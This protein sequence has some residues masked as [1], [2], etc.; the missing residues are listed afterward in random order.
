MC[1]PAC[2]EFTRTALDRDEVHEAEVLE[3]GSRDYNGTVRALIEPHGPKS[4]VGLDMLDG[5]GVD[6]VGDAGQLVDRFGAEAFDVVIATELL[7]HARRWR[8]VVNAL[9]EVLRPGGLLV[10]TTRSKGFPF[11]GCPD[12]FWRYEAHDFAVIFDDLLIDRLELDDP[13]TPGVLLR[14]RKPE[15]YHQKD[16]KNY[17]LY[18]IIARRRVGDVDPV[19][20]CAFNLAVQGWN[21][22]KAVLPRQI[23]DPVRR[24]IWRR[25]LS[26]SDRRPTGSANPS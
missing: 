24:R 11:H 9:K 22:A 12:D 16:L 23:V 10:V 14:A 2:L 5:P 3:V 21:A 18:S 17:R 13:R 19:S 8:E 20:V 7:E 4:Y 1:T 26:P 15:I 6:V 25:A